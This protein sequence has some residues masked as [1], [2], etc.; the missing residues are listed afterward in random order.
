[1]SQY[2]IYFL[3]L[4]FCLQYLRFACHLWVNRYVTMRATRVRFS[5]EVIPVDFPISLCCQ[6][7]SVFRS[8]EFV[9]WVADNT[10]ANFGWS[11]SW[12][13]RL[14]LVVW[15]MVKYLRFEVDGLHSYHLNWWNLAVQVCIVSYLIL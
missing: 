5:V 11:E 13:H 9:K 2:L 1:M 10:E 4:I 14:P 6:V 12:S 7:N 3:L 15:V 8:S